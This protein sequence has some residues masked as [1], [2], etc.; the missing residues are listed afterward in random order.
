MV[1]IRE[2]KGK[3]TA[4]GF[5]GKLSAP[6]ARAHTRTG[7]SRRY[8]LGRAVAL[9]IVETCFGTAENDLGIWARVV[10]DYPE[11]ADDILEKAR[12]IAAEWRQGEIRYPVQRFQKW[13]GRRYPKRPGKK[14]GQFRG[15]ETNSIGRGPM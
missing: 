9:E 1:A 3:E 14:N 5:R 11:S 4:R 12:A 7:K 13:L 15:D 2:S 10:Y 8:R 6:G